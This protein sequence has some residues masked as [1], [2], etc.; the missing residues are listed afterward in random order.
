[1]TLIETWIREGASRA[2]RTEVLAALPADASTWTV[3]E[4][5]FPDRD[6]AA[7][8]RDCT[9]IAP[10]LSQ[11]QLRFPNIVEHESRTSA[12]LVVN[13]SWRGRKFG[14]EQLA[15]LAALNP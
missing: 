14:D 5:V 2:L 6:P 12:D 8:A 13:A 1:V 4:A 3:G 15:E 11:V 10:I 9:A 7:V